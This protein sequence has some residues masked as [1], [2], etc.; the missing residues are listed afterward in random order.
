MPF[1]DVLEWKNLFIEINGNDGNKVVTLLVVSQH[2]LLEIF[3]VCTERCYGRCENM[4][5]QVL[6]YVLCQ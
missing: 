5:L 6:I 3:K 1:L 2:K 4:I